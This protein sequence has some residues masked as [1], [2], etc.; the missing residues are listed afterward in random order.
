MYTHSQGIASIVQCMYNMCVHRNDIWQRTIFVTTHISNTL[1]ARALKGCIQYC[2][3]MYVPVDRN[4]IWAKKHFCDYTYIH[5]APGH[6]RDASSTYCVCMCLCTGMTWQLSTWDEECKTIFCGCSPSVFGIAVFLGSSPSC[7][8]PFSKPYTQYIYIWCNMYIILK[9]S[10]TCSFLLQVI[11]KR[12][13]RVAR[14]VREGRRGRE[15][16]G[17]ERRKKETKMNPSPRFSL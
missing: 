1:P 3:R 14:E 6:W 4:N 9:C 8:F 15:G 7:I 16:R 17:K 10:K 11:R 2:V 13:G 5:N 12:V